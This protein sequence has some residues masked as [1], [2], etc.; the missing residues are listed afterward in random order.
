MWHDSDDANDH[1]KKHDSDDANDDKK[2]ASGWYSNV[3]GQPQD[4]QSDNSS[5]WRSGTQRWGKRGGKNA[6]YYTAR[7]NAKNKGEE[8][9]RWWDSQYSKDSFL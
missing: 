9:L 2:W 3:S 1:K 4:F 8:Y 5:Y 7:A 6:A